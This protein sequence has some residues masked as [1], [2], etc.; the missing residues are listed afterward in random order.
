MTGHAGCASL[1][2]KPIPFRDDSLN[3]RVRCSGNPHA[4]LCVISAAEAMLTRNRIISGHTASRNVLLLSAGQQAGLERG[5]ETGTAP[6]YDSLKS[7]FRIHFGRDAAISV[8]AL[9]G[10]PGPCV[11]HASHAIAP[12][13]TRIGTRAFAWNQF[14]IVCLWFR[15]VA[16]HL[17]PEDRL[18]VVVAFPAEVK[19]SGRQIFK[20]FIAIA[21]LSELADDFGLEEFQK[22][23]GYVREMRGWDIG[24]FS[25]ASA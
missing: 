22:A 18:E 20:G 23:E 3:K 7:K 24:V 13:K 2:L 25:L 10:I 14:R 16:G 21:K 12:A 8:T 11:A 6:A 4:D 17:P 15:G 5:Q 1:V 9:S 19:N